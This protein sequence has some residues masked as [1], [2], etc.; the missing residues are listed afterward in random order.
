MNTSSR[1]P[2]RI[3]LQALII[4]LAL[5]L[6]PCIAPSPA[7]AADILLIKD[8]DIKP[9]LDVVQGFKKTC[10][11]ST[12]ELDIDDSA[13]I[14]QAL[15]A[16]PAAVVAIGSKAL[17]KLK[18]LKTV[19]V[20][21]VMVTPAESA[22]ADG[23]NMSGISMEIDPRTWLDTM[24][25]LFPGITRIGVLY[26]PDNTG[27]FVQKAAAAARERGISLILKKTTDPRK[28]P[29]LLDELRGK[30]DVLWML[31]DAT[32]ANSTVLDSFLLFS[33]RYNVPLFSFSRYLV[34]Q[35]ATA[36]LRIDPLDIGA[37]A[38]E[39][40]SALGRGDKISQDAYS[41]KS[42]L[43]VNMRVR[44]KMGLVL[45]DELVRSAERVE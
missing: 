36:A 5:L 4:A 32:F 22:E 16:R 8:S 25:G 20:I 7:L 37:Q 34:E 28:A 6:C 15:K 12:I 29:A 19:P 31:P 26:D 24:T 13:E 10:G 1:T 21:H 33:F 35:G 30:I 44:P 39:L 45:N 43:I 23:E 27:S 14:E 42:R 3:P 17:R 2:Y 9:Y 18:V 40:A 41:R 11:C 38:G